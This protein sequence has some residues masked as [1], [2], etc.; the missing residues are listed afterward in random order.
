MIIQRIL[1]LLEEKNLKM[2]DLCRYRDINTST[3]TNW[4]NRG[5]DPPAKYIFPI[6]EFLSVS[7]EYILTGTEKQ[8]AF[9]ISTEDTEWLHLIH[10]LPKEAQLE[11]KGEMKGY[12]KGIGRLGNSVE[13]REAK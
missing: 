3:M 12:L 13:M 11:F 6:C 1:Q 7:C 10:S 8:N 4:K 5:T 2:A 9:L